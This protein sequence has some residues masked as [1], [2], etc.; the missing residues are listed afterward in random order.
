[1]R[2][3][4]TTLFFAQPVLINNET[5][6]SDFVN[7]LTGS[8][9]LF[10]KHIYLKKNKLEIYRIM[11]IIKK[12]LPGNIDVIKKYKQTK[13]II[14]LLSFLPENNCFLIYKASVNKNNHIIVLEFSGFGDLHIENI[15]KYKVICKR[16]CNDL[17]FY[18]RLN[19]K[20]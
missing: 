19:L 6:K 16:I 3:P 4:W 9:Y 13:E 12:L 20:I 7:V 10:T 14:G 5:L 17:D 11:K 8:I 15:N 1:M 2:L 18:I